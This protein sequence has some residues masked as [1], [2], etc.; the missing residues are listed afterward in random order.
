M[1]ERGSISAWG[2]QDHGERYQDPLLAGFVSSFTDTQ[3]WGLKRMTDT[4]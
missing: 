1:S 2:E 4:A 3:A